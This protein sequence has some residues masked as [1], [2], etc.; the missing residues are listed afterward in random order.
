[1]ISAI[2]SYVVP[3]SGFMLEL[4]A[5]DWSTSLGALC[6]LI[7]A[8]MLRPHGDQKTS[9]HAHRPMEA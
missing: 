1:M 6:L 2:A 3:S 9:Q 5:A 4:A 8:L 7:G